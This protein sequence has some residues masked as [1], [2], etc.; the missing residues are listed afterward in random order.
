MERTSKI[1]GF[2]FYRGRGYKESNLRVYLS[3]GGGV[4]TV[5][6]PICKGEKSV[7]GVY[8]S[9]GGGGVRSGWRLGLSVMQ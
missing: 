3:G 9:G 2:F 4:M 1:S 7:I 5:A 6:L 8:F